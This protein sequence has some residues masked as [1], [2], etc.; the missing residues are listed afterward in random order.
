[1]EI[2]VFNFVLIHI[3]HKTRQD[4]VKVHVQPYWPLNQLARVKIIVLNHISQIL[5]IK[6]AF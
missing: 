5:E 2:Y 3:S 1:M 4:H 6:D